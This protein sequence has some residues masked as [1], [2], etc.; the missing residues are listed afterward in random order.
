MISGVGSGS[1]L[2]RVGSGSESLVGSQS[3]G[4]WE[5]GVRRGSDLAPLACRFGSSR[6]GAASSKDL[7]RLRGREGALDSRDTFNSTLP[8]PAPTTPTTHHS[9]HRKPSRSPPT[10]P[11]QLLR[12]AP[13]SQRL[14]L[15]KTFTLKFQRLPLPTFVQASNREEEFIRFHQ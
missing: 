12:P 7:A 4:S 6:L 15:P 1:D 5:L 11:N 14:P 10:P 3:V 2:A 8:I 13:H 9:Q